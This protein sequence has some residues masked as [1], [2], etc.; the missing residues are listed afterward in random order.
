MKT[1]NVTGGLCWER[2][3]EWEQNGEQQQNIEVAWLLLIENV[4]REK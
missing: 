4:V 3:R 2:W 1:E